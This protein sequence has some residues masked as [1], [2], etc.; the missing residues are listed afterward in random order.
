MERAYDFHELVSCANILNHL[1]VIKYG[2]NSL[3]FGRV[4]I[5][6]KTYG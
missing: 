1:S 2:D 5:K 6:Q 4:H 3:Q